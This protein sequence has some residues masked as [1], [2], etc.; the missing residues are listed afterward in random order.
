MNKQH[1]VGGTLRKVM[2]EEIIR[3]IQ[4]VSRSGATQI[5]ETSA[6]I[7][8]ITPRTLLKWKGPVEKGGWKELQVKDA[9]DKMVKKVK[10]R[11]RRKFRIQ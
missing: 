4:Q 11:S 1:L 7:L 10:R 8:G 9:V 6:I 2:A 3:V 5:I